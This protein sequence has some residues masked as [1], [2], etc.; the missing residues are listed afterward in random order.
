M[1]VIKKKTLDDYCTVYPSIEPVITAWYRDMK[2]NTYQNIS[3]LRKTFPTADPVM[4][5]TLICFN[6][7][8]NNYR[9]LVRI[10]WGKTVFIRELLIYAEYTKKYVKGKNK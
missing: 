2:Q 1:T 8:G 5:N 9:L 10:T 4:N 7:K 3:E 6:I